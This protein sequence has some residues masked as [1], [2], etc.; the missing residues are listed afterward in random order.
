MNSTMCSAICMGNSR[1]D[2]HYT[3]CT[4][5]FLLFYPLIMASFPWQQMRNNHSV[6]AI[7]YVSGIVNVFHGVDS[8]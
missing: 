3:H 7:V 4:L 5:Y 8:V 6:V 2:G 1:D